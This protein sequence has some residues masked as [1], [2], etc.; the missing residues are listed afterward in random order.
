[1]FTNFV[2]ISTQKKKNFKNR[3]DIIILSLSATFTVN[4]GAER[5]NNHT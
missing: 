5:D 4:I 2:K 3:D 1:M